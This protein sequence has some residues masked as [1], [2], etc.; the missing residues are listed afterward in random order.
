MSHD[1]SS[2]PR[3]PSSSARNLGGLVFHE[4][5]VIEIDPA[6]AS[7]TEHSLSWLCR[8]SCG[9][10]KSLQSW[11]LIEGRSKSCRK[12]SNKRRRGK[13][14]PRNYDEDLTGRSFGLWTVI[15]PSHPGKGGRY[16]DCRCECGATK[17]IRTAELGI[18]SAC[19]KC[20][21]YLRRKVPYRAMWGMIVHR[22]KKY[23]HE[24]TINKQWVFDLLEKQGYRCA[25]S[26]LPIGIATWQ[27]G[28]SRGETTASP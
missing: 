28:H 19:L 24:L 17:S 22:A 4:W 2:I 14:R 21:H 6:K 9:V 5:T 23:G 15:G 25:L 18:R 26:G 3:F 27:R 16:W 10:V 13:K 11:T 12:C 7:N 20:S 8:C 1:D